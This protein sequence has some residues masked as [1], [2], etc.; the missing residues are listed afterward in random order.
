MS[1]GRFDPF[2]TKVDPDTA[3]RLL[4]GNGLYTGD[5]QVPGETHAYVLRSPHAHARILSID[6]SAA[7]AMPGVVGIFTHADC[8]RLE[9]VGISTFLVGESLMRKDDVAAATR[10]LLTGSADRMAAE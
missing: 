8:K 5:I 3:L 9:M 1:A 10:E 4:K 2:T 7:K 6:T